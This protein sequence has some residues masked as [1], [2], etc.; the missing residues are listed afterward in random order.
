MTGAIHD[1]SSIL[2]SQVKD[3][4]LTNV[5]RDTDELIA[6]R[7]LGLRS[8]M[9]VPVVS[10]KRTFG[11][12]GLL[13]A[14][15]DRTYG[16]D[17]LAMAVEIGRRAGEAVDN[18]L[19]Y[20]AAERA[21]QARDEFL[22]VASHELRTPLSALLLQLGSLAKK[23][24]LDG[25]QTNGLATS[26]KKIGAAL[27]HTNRLAK[28]V[29]NLL[30]VSR[31]STKSLALELEECDLAS[32]ARDVVERFT[33]EA[34][35]SKCQLVVQSHGDAL[36]SWDRLRVEQVVTN[37]LSNAIKYG[38]GSPIEVAVDADDEHARIAIRDHGIGIAEEDQ[39][40]VFGRFERAVPLRHYGGLGLGLYIVRQIVEAHRGT[41]KVESQRGLGTTFIVTL[42]RAPRAAEARSIPPLSAPSPPVQ[43]VP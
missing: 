18:A 17:D 33:E 1:E 6:L 5:A 10:R 11:T 15:V 14:D 19:L 25:A 43:L 28:L 26:A 27:R 20:R 35:E 36:G 41:V 24:A 29:D 9:V 2:V 23:V 40:R 31:L 22:S 42:P 12:I 7:A 37:L 32:V 38:R 30:D 8:A 39:T 16:S 34:K 3:E 21:V 13:S 4:L